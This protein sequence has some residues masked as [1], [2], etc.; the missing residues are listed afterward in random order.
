[1]LQNHHYPNDLDIFTITP[2]PHLCIHHSSSSQHLLVSSLQNVTWES[3]LRELQQNAQ[4]RLTAEEA[5]EYIVKIQRRLLHEP[6]QYIL[7]QWDFLDYTVSIRKPLLCPRPETEELVTMIVQEHTTESPIHVLDVGCG[8]GVIGLALADQMNEAT[9]EAIDIEPIAVTTSRENALLILGN[10][11]SS[12]YKVTQSSAQE[13]EAE[14]P[15]DV[16]VSNPPY[17]P[18]KDMETLTKDVLDYESHTALCGGHDGMDIIRVIID[19]LPT[20]CHKGAVCWMEV[21][22]SQPSMI[23]DMLT[24]HGRVHF[25]SMHLD[26]FG[27]ERFVKLRVV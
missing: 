2:S 24:T 9:V 18:Q 10:E 20:W 7:G 15:F 17:I 22:P 25:E 16:V 4:R 27:K 6:L 11:Q 13:Y 14:H 21:D 23:R 1:M 8:T 3:G 26:M 12:C 19:R 5:Q